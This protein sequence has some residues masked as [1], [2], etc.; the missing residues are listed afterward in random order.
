[1]I[2]LEMIVHLVLQIILLKNGKAVL[3]AMEPVKFWQVIVLIIQE[4]L[5]KAGVEFAVKTHIPII[6][7][8]VRDVVE[9]EDIMNKGNAGESSTFC[10]IMQAAVRCRSS[11]QK[12]ASV[13]IPIDRMRKAHFVF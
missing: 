13:V 1:M 11:V 2:Y 5:L 7:K 10:T 12:N 3:Y 4:M 8:N 6:T 9:M